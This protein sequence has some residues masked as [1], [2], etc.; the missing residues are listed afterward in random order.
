M[1]DDKVM[2]MIKLLSLAC[3]SDKHEYCTFSFAGEDV[4]DKEATSH[5]DC[6]DAFKLSLI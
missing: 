4:L 1:I 6:L 2:R 5:D 3:L